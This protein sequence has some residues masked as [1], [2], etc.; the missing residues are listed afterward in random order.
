[1]SSQNHC[2]WNYYKEKAKEKALKNF[3]DFLDNSASVCYIML[4]N[5]E[6]NRD[7]AGT[8]RDKKYLKKIIQKCFGF[9]DNRVTDKLF[10]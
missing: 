3:P 2:L 5:V 9:L 10:C 4:I 1:M 6:Y 7:K 8:K